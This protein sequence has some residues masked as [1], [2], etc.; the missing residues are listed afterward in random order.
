MSATP[1]PTP[2]VVDL[3]ALLAII[4]LIMVA[5]FFMVMA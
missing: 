3:R 5:V 1:S 2:G 4:L